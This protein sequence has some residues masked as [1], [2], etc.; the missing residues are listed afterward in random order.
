MFL[1]KTVAEN[2]A[3]GRIKEGYSAFPEGMTPE[4][5]KLLSASPAL[6]EM[7]LGYI[8]YYRTHKTLS[9]PLLTAIRF[10]SADECGHNFCLDFNRKILQMAGMSNEDID[11]MKV[12]PASAPLED[13]EQAM[14]VFVTKALKA[15]NAVTQADVDVLRALGWADADI[16]DALMH[17]AN[18]V[19][20]SL[21]FNSFTK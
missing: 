21:V 4:P 8:Q 7:Q 19:A 9:F 1:L 2:E 17:G 11:A 13:K 15:P 5:L 16:Y 14:L 3:Q 10:M 18:M 6:F 12:D 20:S